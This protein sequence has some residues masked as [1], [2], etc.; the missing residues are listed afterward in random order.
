EK[1][2]SVLKKAIDKVD[3][4]PNNLWFIL[5]DASDLCLMFDSDE[6]D[7]LYLNFSDPWPKKRHSKRRLTDGGQLV[8]YQDILVSNGSIYFKT[9]NRHLFEFS[10][11]MFTINHW[12]IEE[13][14]LNLHEDQDNIVT[15]EYEDRFT[16]KGN[17]IYY[18][19]VKKWK[20]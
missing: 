6:V 4:K 12:R 8:Q 20:E 18:V 2:A 19:R 14:S 10:I 5:G 7:T 9:D 13:L 15:T 11:Q 16:E 17:I 3:V 1:E